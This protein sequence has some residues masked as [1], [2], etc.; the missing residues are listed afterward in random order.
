MIQIKTTQYIEYMKKN[1]ENKILL[2]LLKHILFNPY[3]IIKLIRWITL[4]RNRKT[5]LK[6][7]VYG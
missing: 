7:D 6:K 5:N 3:Q 1:I 2:E 4:Q